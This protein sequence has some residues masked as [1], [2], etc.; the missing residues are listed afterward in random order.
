MISLE[1]FVDGLR[2]EEIKMAVRM[3]HTDVKD[4]KS[5]LLY[6]LKVET[7]IQASC[8]DLH[9]IREPRVTADEPC[10][11]RCIKRIEKL[12]EKMQALIAQRQNRRR[13]SITCW[14]FKESSDEKPSWQ[15][16][17]PF[18]PTTKRYWDLWDSLHLRNGVLYRKWES[19]DE[20]TFWWQLILP[21]TRVSTVLKELHGS[22]T[23]GDFGVMKTLQK[24][25]ECF[26][27]NNVRSDVEKCYR[28][29]DPCAARKG[30]RNALEEDCSCIMWENLSNE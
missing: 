21:K 11:S 1:Y 16:I 25:R 30:P 14:E 15:D 26:Y 3:A 22:P 28:K 13:R 2:D 29:C 10:E 5:S 4:L 20:K 9:S 18:H 6:A 7:A 27:R 19:D 24:V 8:I 17:A 23:G 12:K